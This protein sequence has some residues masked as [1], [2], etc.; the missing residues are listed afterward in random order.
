MLQIEGKVRPQ[1]EFSHAP[2]CLGNCE[3]FIGQK[4][5]VVAEGREQVCWGQIVKD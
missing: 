5:F 4:Q 2:F 1:A 3:K